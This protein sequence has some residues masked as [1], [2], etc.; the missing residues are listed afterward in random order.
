MDFRNILDEILRT[1]ATSFDFAFV[2]CV[3]IIAYFAIKV[4]DKLNGEKPVL[5][6]QKRIVTLVCALFLGIIYYSMKL[7]DVRIVLN[8]VILSLVAFDVIIKPIIK[9]LGIDYK[10]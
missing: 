5:V 7:G 4:I 9:K 10:H 6:W 3:N 8:S 1:T 2:I